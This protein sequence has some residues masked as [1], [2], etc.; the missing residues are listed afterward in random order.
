MDTVYTRL[1]GANSFAHNIMLLETA[2][3]L[4]LNKAESDVHLEIYRAACIKQFEV[5]VSQSLS[6]LIGYQ[7]VSE[8]GL[9]TLTAFSAHDT[10]RSA[11]ILGGP[12]PITATKRW[13]NYYKLRSKTI[14]T[15]E[16]SVIN[17]ILA[18]LPKFIKDSKA[19]AQSLQAG[20]EDR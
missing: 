5:I 13:I 20:Y 3:T 18:I 6:L 17:E 4:L 2:Y 8:A 16:L 15:Y 11:A 12:L 1:S 19:L 10:Y 14:A 7:S 9:I